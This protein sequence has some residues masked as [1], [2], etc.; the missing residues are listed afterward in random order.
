MRTRTA[1]VLA[2][3][4]VLIASAAAVVAVVAADDDRWS[5]DRGSMMFSGDGAGRG[6]GGMHGVQVTSEYAYLVEM[7]A[8]HE[9]AV[10]AA[11]E[12]QRSE[13]PAMRAF[14]ESIVSSQTAQIDQME[15]WLVEWYPDRS[16]RTDYRPL[17]RDLGDLSGNE[18]DRA[19]LADMVWHHMAAVMMSQQLLARGI[20]DHSQVDA[21]ATTIRDD[22]HA[23]IFQMQEW[24]D[25]WFGSSASMHAW[26]R[27]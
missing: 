14:G 27:R 3:L 16:G 11:R 25:E 12:L 18:L 22:Q 23:E 4:A 9:E 15:D 10:M 7:V 1:L 17:M 20:A 5:G 26:S 24:L 6:M 2:I 13:R 19:F 8:H 21:L